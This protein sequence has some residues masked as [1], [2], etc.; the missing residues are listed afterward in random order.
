VLECGAEDFEVE[1]EEFIIGT[2][3]TNLMEVRDNLEAK[4]VVVKSS[5]IELIPKNLQKVEEKDVES[6][7]NLMEALED[8]EDIK[9]V[10]ANFDI[11]E[12]LLKIYQ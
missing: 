5:E 2:D 10:Y 7:I 3:P 6:V 1:N 8:N 12:D 4:N 11:D 9:N